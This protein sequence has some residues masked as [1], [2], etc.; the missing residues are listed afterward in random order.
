MVSVLAVID[1][2]RAQTAVH[3]RTR[4]SVIPLPASLDGS[5]WIEMRNVLLHIDERGVIRIDRL[6]GQVV[7]DSG[8]PAVLDDA[9]SFTIR[10]TRGTTRLTG[11]DLA[12]LLN[13]VVF[14]YPG[15]PLRRLRARMDGKAVHLSGT[16]RKGVNLP[17]SITA[18]PTLEPDGRVRMHPTRVRI[19][20]IDGAKL[21]RALGLELDDLIDMRKARGA[22]AEGNDILL[23][24]TKILPPPMIEARLESIGVVGT[25]LVQTFMT[26]PL[27]SIFERYVRPDSMHP[28]LV[29]FRGGRLRFGKLEMTD[30]DL[31]IVDAD[32]SDPFDLYLA[33]Y[34]EQ[35]VAGTSR[36]LETYGLRVMMPDYDDLG[37]EKGAQVA[38]GH[39]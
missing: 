29:Y 33:R 15:A 4:A 24:P 20:G 27:D 18:T 17:F 8:T 35:L 2:P 19:L 7:T 32:Q 14:A 16:L 25:E 23:D 1:A 21:L 6:R 31:Q 26:T 22:V 37:A 10:V 3:T 12:S 11:D 5:T 9:T 38:R 13:S 39:N 30:T 34:N 28:N 36:N